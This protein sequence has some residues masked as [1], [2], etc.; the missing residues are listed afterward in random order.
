MSCTSSVPAW[1]LARIHGDPPVID[2]IGSSVLLLV[3]VA[4]VMVISTKIFRYG[5]LHAQ[6][7]RF[8]EL[9]RLALRRER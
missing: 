4:V 3:T 8:L 7:S 2:L 1:S 5:A 6:Q 9:L